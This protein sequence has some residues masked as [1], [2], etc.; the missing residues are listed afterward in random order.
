MKNHENIEIQQITDISKIVE[1]LHLGTNIP[2]SS[3]MIPF[4]QSD[5]NTLNSRSIVLI[6]E[7]HVTG[8]SLIYDD[9]GK[10]LY[11]GFF[12]V[13]DH[14]EKKIALLIDE[15]KKFAIT[16]LNSLKFSL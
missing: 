6:E 8:H 13:S 2:V 4:I 14:D 5:L 15:I 1:Y 7:G 16:N 10:I 11:F 3:D 9:G 12:G